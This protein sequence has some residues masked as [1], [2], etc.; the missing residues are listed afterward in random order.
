MIYDNLRVIAELNM[1]YIKN[2]NELVTNPIHD[3]DKG[4]FLKCISFS[5]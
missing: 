2:V 4:S 1:K 3:V 5:A